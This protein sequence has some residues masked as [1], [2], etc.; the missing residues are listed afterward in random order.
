MGT[1]KTLTASGSVNDGNGGNNYTITFVINTTGVIQTTVAATNIT[2]GPSQLVPYGQPVTFT[3]TATNAPGTGNPVGSVEFYANGRT[4]WGRRACSARTAL[5]ATWI[6]KSLL[7]LTSPTCRSCRAGGLVTAIFTP[8]GG[9][10]SVT[11]PPWTEY[12]VDGVPVQGMYRE[13]DFNAGNSN[14]N[15]TQA[16]FFGALASDSLATNGEG[17]TSHPSIVNTAINN[18]MADTLLYQDIVYGYSSGGIKTYEFAANP[19]T[20]YSIRLYLGDPRAAYGNLSMGVRAYDSA[21]ARQ[22]SPR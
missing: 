20:T 14:A 10:G 11:S 7:L 2:A 13:F 16:G 12:V 8:E 9:G 19:N 21:P 6:Y 5:S 3:F 17:W 18:G 4:R 15:V 22:A 1:G